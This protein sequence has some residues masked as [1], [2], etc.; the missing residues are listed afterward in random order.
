M[1]ESNIPRYVMVIILGV[2][3]LGFG[4]KGTADIMNYSSEWNRFKSTAVSTQAVID[5]ISSHSSRGGG[6]TIVYIKFTDETGKEWDSTIDRSCDGFKIGGTINVYYDRKNPK[7]TMLEPDIYLK[8]TKK[9]D[10]FFYVLGVVLIA[11]GIVMSRIERQ[12]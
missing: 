10:T 9:S 5:D 3:A 4:L 11:A 12:I 7:N 2:M 6:Y 8:R 1:R